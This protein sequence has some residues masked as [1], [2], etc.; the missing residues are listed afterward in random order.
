MSDFDVVILGGGV[1]G[2]ACAT[3]LVRE[4]LSTC[5]VERNPYIGGGAITREITVPGY[6]HDL[7]GSSHVWIQCNEDFKAIQPELE[8]YGL[9][10]IE[11]D[12]QITGHPDKNG[13]PGIVIYKDIDA[14]CESIAA[15]SKADAKRYRQVFDDFKLIREGF[16]KNFFSPPAPPSSMA[17]ALES[18]ENGLRRLQEFSMSARA[19]VETYFENDFIRAVMLNWA[20]APQILP[21]QEGAGQSF[22]IMIPAIHHYGQAIPEGGSQQLPNAM[23]AYI[24]DHGGR[25]LTDSTANKVLVENGRATGI[26]VEGQADILAKRA[27]VSS[28]E[29]KQTFLKLIDSDALDESFLDMVRGYSFGNISICRIH[30]ALNEEPRYNNGENMSACAYHRTVDSMAQMNRFY[31][32]IAL[33]KPPSDPF[34][35]AACWTKLDPTR[36]PAGHH[37]MIVDTYVSN[38][39]ADGRTWGEIGEEYA[40]NVLV[41]TLQQ[42]APNVN[43]QTIVAHCVQTGEDLARDNLSF[44]DGTTAGGE[45]IGA[46]LG[47]FRPFPGYAH[48]RAPIKDLYMTGP[49]CH[50]GGGISAM[51]T[52]TGRVMLDDMGIKQADF[53]Q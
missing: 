6:K 49:H 7:Y 23:A 21:D 36:A 28:L 1:N 17:R 3:T 25:V 30:L 37:T 35:W 41:P 13:G 46:Q 9:K 15:Y 33:G 10:Y 22:Y 8:R 50:P 42:Y 47:S 26:G 38:W 18:S 45:R 27:V 44:V 32:E 19:W 52:I 24:E 11:P 29:P 16:I 34:L 2:L 48:Y 12:H 4:G 51:G 43:E 53:W 20:L 40:L 14:T 31:A 39:L 5:V